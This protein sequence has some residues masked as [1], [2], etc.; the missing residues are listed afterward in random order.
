MSDATA[1][2]RQP[3]VLV[4]LHWGTLA[5]ILAG[6]VAVLLRE[7]LSAALL[8]RALLDVHRNAGL[9]VLLATA[10]RLAMRWRLRRRRPVVV[11]PPLLRL[12]AGATHLA[13]YALLIGLP[14]LGWALS[15]ARGQP[16]LLFGLLPLPVLTGTDPDRAETLADWHETAAWALAALVALHA[17]AALWHHCVRGDAVLRAMWPV[18]RAADPHA[19]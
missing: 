15:D 4:L 3:R 18:R 12:A 9:L 16:P 11:L 6:V 10:L 2:A 8:R 5:L 17:L 14:L 1:V 19:S 7:G 13:L